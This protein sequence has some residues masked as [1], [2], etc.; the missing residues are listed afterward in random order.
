MD[1][2]KIGFPAGTLDENSHRIPLVFSNNGAFARSKPANFSVEK[3][4]EAL[5]KRISSGKNRFGN[6]EIEKPQIV[7]S[8]ENEASGIVFFADKA[9]KKFFEIWKN[10]LGSFQIEQKFLFLARPENFEKNAAGTPNSAVPEEFSVELPVAKH[11]TEERALISK[12]T[13]KKSLTI[14][15]KLEALS[16]WEFWEAKSSF[17]R[18]H[19]IRIHAAESKITILGEKIYAEVPYVKISEFRPKFR[20][21]KGEDKDFYGNFCLHL[22]EA[23]FA[24]PSDFEDFPAKISI[25]APLPENFETLLKKLRERR[26]ARKS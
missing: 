21:N 5:R 13:G 17:P 11:F 23:N 7:F 14:F 4:L 18:F 24:F 19:Q 6:V 22:A 20:L 8:A 9:Q 26:F 12:T 10:A 2:E 25:S 15:K 1:A 16:P 3:I